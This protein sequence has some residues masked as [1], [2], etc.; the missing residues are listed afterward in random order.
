MSVSFVI[1]YMIIHPFDIFEQIKNI[2]IN[3]VARED[4][5]IL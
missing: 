1:P 2:A 3:F 5:K 4:V